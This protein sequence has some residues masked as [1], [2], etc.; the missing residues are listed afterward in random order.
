MNATAIIIGVISLVISWM[1]GGRLIR[2][3]KNGQMVFFGQF[4][5]WGPFDREKQPALFWLS[6]LWAAIASLAI[7]AWL[8]IYIDGGFG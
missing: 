4:R 6:T 7:I 1:A 5:D 3:I 8:L 2:G